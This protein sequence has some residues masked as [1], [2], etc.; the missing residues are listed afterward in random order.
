MVVAILGSLDST[1]LQPLLYIS[2]RIKAIASAHLTMS[3]DVVVVVH[4]DSFCDGEERR[5]KVAEMVKE[6][7]V[8]NVNVEVFKAVQEDKGAHCI[9][10]H[11]SLEI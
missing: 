11:F 9:L 6:S 2:R 1:I 5:F 10:F 3:Y 7:M 8:G 4:L